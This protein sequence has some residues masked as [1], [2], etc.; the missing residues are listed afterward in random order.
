[1]PAVRRLRTV[2]D[3]KIALAGF[4]R[5]IEKGKLDHQTGRCLIYG[6]ATLT[7]IMRDHDLEARLDA[8]EAGRADEP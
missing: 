3:V 4:I 5:A 7:S 2:E 1:M 8:L 6:C